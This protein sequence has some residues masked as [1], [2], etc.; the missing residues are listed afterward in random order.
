MF[1]LEP[2]IAAVPQAD[3]SYR[4][5]SWLTVSRSTFNCTARQGIAAVKTGIPPNTGRAYST[6]GITWGLLAEPATA[7][8][9]NNFDY[10]TWTVVGTPVLT[11][12]LTPGGIIE[13]KEV[14]DNDAVNGEAIQELSIGD[15]VGN[16]MHTLSAW[17]WLYQLGLGG[18]ASIIIDVGPDKPRIDVSAQETVWAYRTNSQVTSATPAD[19]IT[20]QPS[21]EVT[22]QAIFRVYQPQLE[23]LPYATSYIEGSRSVETLS[24]PTALLAP[25]GFFKVSFTIR[26]HFANTAMKEGYFSLVWFDDSNWAFINRNQLGLTA[27]NIYLRIAGEDL[28]M[29]PLS[30]SEGQTLIIEIEHSASKRFISVAG[31]TVGNG[32]IAGA[33]MAAI[34]P[35]PTTLSLF[36]RSSLGVEEALDVPEFYPQGKTFEIPKPI[37]PNVHTF[38]RFTDL[39]MRWA[40]GERAHRLTSLCAGLVQDC[41]ADAVRQIGRWGHPT[42]DTPLDALGY[43]LRDYGLP[44]YIEPYATTLARVSNAW[45]TH[46]IAGSK[47]MLEAEAAICG[48]AEPRVIPTP[49]PSITIET[50]SASAPLVWGNFFYSAPGNI[51]EITYGG[52]LPKVMNHNLVRA[53]RWFRPAREWFWAVKPVSMNAWIRGQGSVRSDINL[54][55]AAVIES[56]TFVTGTLTG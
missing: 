14:Q 24:A 23:A 19:N 43:L 21:N 50:P 48:L 53:M 16:T 47:A 20:I 46:E 34:S 6:D 31:A 4:L 5:P 37:T 38:V 8:I 36:S 1:T 7:N 30:W 41:L 12:V 28:T 44:Q 2:F 17:T 27:Y 25:D 51:L 3:G 18:P 15:I 35:L 42:K 49:G 33:A 32:A 55:F 22:D 45:A 54:E 52:Q 13:L 10:S 56:K 29:G 40:R 39:F 26:P 9:V 11:S